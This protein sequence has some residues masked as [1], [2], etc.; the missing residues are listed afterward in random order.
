MTKIIKAWRTVNAVKMNESAR[1][2][3]RAA[4]PSLLKSE[5][6]P[7]QAPHSGVMF[8]LKKM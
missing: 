5:D 8:A 6:A 4:R 1:T 7:K 2:L 3:V